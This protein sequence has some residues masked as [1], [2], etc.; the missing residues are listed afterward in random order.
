[1]K[2]LKGGASNPSIKI[3]AENEIQLIQNLIHEG[4]PKLI[5]YLLT[6]FPLSVTIF[7]LQSGVYSKDIVTNLLIIK[8]RF[9]NYLP[10]SLYY[11]GLLFNNKYKF[12]KN[13]Y[14]YNK[15]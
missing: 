9:H 12:Q 7:S 13:K 4:L 1:L 6:I 8:D 10:F 2:R 3:A 5:D 14:I 15:L 11:L